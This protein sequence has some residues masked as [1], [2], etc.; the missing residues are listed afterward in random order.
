MAR[1]LRQRNIIFSLL[2]LLLGVTAGRA[3]DLSAIKQV[4]LDHGVQPPPPPKRDEKDWR[5]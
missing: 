2:A 3:K 1:F 4:M 5:N